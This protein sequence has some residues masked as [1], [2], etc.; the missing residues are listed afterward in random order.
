MGLFI[1]DNLIAAVAPTYTVLMIA[2]IVASFTHGAF[3]GVG[4]VVAAGLVPANK[5][6]SALDRRSVEA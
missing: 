2:R 5:R 3:F 4:S 1:L 6:G